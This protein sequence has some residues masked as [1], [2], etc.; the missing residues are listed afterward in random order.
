[1]NNIQCILSSIVL[2]VILIEVQDYWIMF[3]YLHWVTCPYKGI[4]IFKGNGDVNLILNVTKH[5]N[6][7]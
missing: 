2:I 4:I 1:M 6:I 5:G 3:R 7:Y